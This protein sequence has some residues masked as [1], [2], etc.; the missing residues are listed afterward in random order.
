MGSC[1]YPMFDEFFS[2]PPSVASPV[3]IEEALTHVESTGLPSLTTVDQDLPSPIEPKTCK[4]ALTWTCWIG[5]YKVKLDEFRG[6]LKNKARLIARGYR[7]EEGIDF[8]E[9]FTPVARV[10]VVW[11]FLMF[12]A[13]MNG[14]VD[15]DKPNHVYRLKKAL[16][17][18]NRLH[19][20]GTAYQKAPTC[21]KKNLS[22]PKRNHQS[23]TMV[24][25][26][27][28]IALTAFVDADHAGCQ[29]IRCSTSENLLLKHDILSFI[30]DIGHFG[31]IIY[32]T[33][34]EN[35]EAKKT[36]KMSYPRFTKIII[37]YFMSKDQSISRR[38]K[39]FWH[40]A[41]DDTMF[42]TM[43]C[44]SRQEDT[45]VYGTILPKELANQAMLETKAYK[46]YYA[47]ASGEKTPKLNG[48]EEE[49]TNDD[50]NDDDI[51]SDDHDDS[52]DERIEYDKGEIPDPNL[53]NVDQTEH[54]EEDVD[55]RVHTPSD[56]K[57]TNDEKIHDEENINHE[58]RM[59]E[60][61]EDEVTK[62]LYKD[63]NMNLGNG[64]I[65]M[66]YVDQ[67]GSGQQN[68]SQELGFEQEEEDAHVTFTPVL[69]TQ[70]ANESIKSS[71][72]SSDF[73]SKLLNLKNPYPTDNEI[74]YLMD[75]T[76]RHATSRSRDNS[77]KDR[78]PSAGSDRGTKRRKS[79][80]E[81]KSSKDSRSKE[82]KYSS[83]SKDTSQSQHKSSGKSAHAEEPCHTVDDSGVQQ[84]Q[85]FNTRN[86]DE[87]PA[88]KVVSKEDWFKKPKRP[89]THDSDWN[90]RQHVDSRPPQTW[91]S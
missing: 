30:R 43:R 10:E 74:A 31:D 87:Q 62:E 75:I 24:L 61:E 3:L 84:D 89:P 44:I 19:A 26:D 12:A 2:T 52:D 76:T 9:S 57:L 45:Q 7:W 79:S 81:A 11:I 1:V 33:D 59:D 77:D 67:G 63:V 53:T 80:K 73:T 35:K 17:K 68:V 4:E 88:N 34:I 6:I 23:R 71:Y 36:N 16:Y 70:K 56:Y 20:R 90:K 39:M 41:R 22:I 29:D 66:T 65:E 13:H 82:N 51:G 86:N 60:E 46:T 50:S 78:D 72:V 25:K 28:A 32:L 64:D 14:F 47:F 91:I 69:D 37:D 83:T 55:E 27:S 38:N 15:P 42:T 8:E 48:E 21:S 5:I 58:E 49:D 40:T 18:L 54:E 85:E